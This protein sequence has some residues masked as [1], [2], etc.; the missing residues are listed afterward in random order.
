VLRHARI[1]S[2]SS[3]RKVVKK[4]HAGVKAQHIPVQVHIAVGTTQITDVK[5]HIALVHSHFTVVKR[6]IAAVKIYVSVAK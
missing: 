4:Q 6:Y 3:Y 2:G 1:V 5:V